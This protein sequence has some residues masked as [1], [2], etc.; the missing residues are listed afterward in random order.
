MIWDAIIFGTKNHKLY[1][2]CL[3]KGSDDLEKKKT[4]NFA[5]V[6]E[7]SNQQMHI[8]KDKYARGIS[9]DRTT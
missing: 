7:I 4:I 3:G 6:C 2:P 5:R 8:M 9:K 1:I